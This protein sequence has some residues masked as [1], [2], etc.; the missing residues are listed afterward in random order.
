MRA[1]LSVAIVELMLIGTVLAQGGAAPPDLAGRYTVDGQNSA[2]E[3]YQG[4]AEIT[5][6]GTMWALHWAFTPE[7]EAMG[8]GLVQQGALAAI[9]QLD[10]GQVGLVL[11]TIDRTASLRLVGIWTVPGAGVTATEILTK[12]SGRE[13]GAPAGAPRGGGRQLGI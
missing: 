13:S 10:S 5:A 4:V 12:I 7:G 8:V 1:V 6:Q 3:P 2:G 9:Y 11:Y